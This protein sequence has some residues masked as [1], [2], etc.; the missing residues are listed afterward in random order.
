VSFIGDDL[1]RIPPMRA[2][3]PR[4]KFVKKVEQ[5]ANIEFVKAAGRKFN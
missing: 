2:M 4:G 3:A 1:V 5:T